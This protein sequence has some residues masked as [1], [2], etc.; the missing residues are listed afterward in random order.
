MLESVFEDHFVGDLHSAG[1]LVWKPL[2]NDTNYMRYASAL[3]GEMMARG[4]T[5]PSVDDDTS[6]RKRG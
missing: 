5:D 6:L 3:A 4:F 2:L 1:K